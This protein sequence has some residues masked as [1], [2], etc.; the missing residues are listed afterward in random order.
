MSPDGYVSV[1]ELL[2]LPKFKK[3]T[4]EDLEAVVSTNDKQRFELAQ[5]SREIRDWR[6]RARQGHSIS[7][8]QEELLLQKITDPEDVPLC[9]HGTFYNK[10]ALIKENGLNRMSRNHIHFAAGQSSIPEGFLFSLNDQSP[11]SAW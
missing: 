9:I 5:P 11:R 3:F 1:E 7:L 4:L 10:W 2:Q 6:I 8:V